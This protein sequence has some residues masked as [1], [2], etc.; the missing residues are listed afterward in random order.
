MRAATSRDA[1]HTIAISA[2]SRGGE[3][4]AS[5]VWFFAIHILFHLAGAASAATSAIRR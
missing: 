1:A 5:M 4:V 3:A 2:V